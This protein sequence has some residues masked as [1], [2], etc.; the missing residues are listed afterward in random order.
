MTHPEE[1]QGCG[2]GA[3]VAHGGPLWLLGSCSR[4][5]GAGRSAAGAW[6]GEGQDCPKAT[7]GHCPAA[8]GDAPARGKRALPQRCREGLYSGGRERDAFPRSLPTSA[9]LARHF[10]SSLQ[11][12]APMQIWGCEGGLVPP[13]VTPMSAGSSCSST[14][15]SCRTMTPPRQF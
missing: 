7:P 8:A 15:V 10:P 5:L 3:E 6:R 4:A 9:L 12:T 13:G 11:E 2:A 1:P 14:R